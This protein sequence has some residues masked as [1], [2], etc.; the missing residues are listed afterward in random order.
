MIADEGTS[1]IPDFVRVAKFPANPR[2]TGGGPSGA[3]TVKAAVPD[4]APDVA[5]IVAR[6]ADR[7]V[8]TPGDTTVATGRLFELQVTR[9]LM[10]TTLPSE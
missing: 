7:P 3:A 2:S 1:V 4:V 10:L 6:P 9:L 5:V 8:A